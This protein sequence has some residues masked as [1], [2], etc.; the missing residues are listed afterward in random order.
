[1]PFQSLSEQGPL[2]RL[3]KLRV[4]PLAGYA[5]AVLSPVLAGWMRWMLAGVIID[6]IAFITFYPAIILSTFVGGLGPGV[7]A[8]ATSA[9]IASYFFLPPYWSFALTPASLASLALF[10]S[11]AAINVMLISL[12]NAVVD[13]IFT[14]QQYTRQIVDAVP[15]GILAVNEQGRMTFVNA[16]LQHLFGYS[17]DELV[18]RSVEVLVPTSV[19]S[20][21]AGLRANFLA[22]PQT[23]LMGA[24]R[25]L[26]GRRKDGSE[27]PVEI[28]LNA[29]RT[30]AGRAVLATVVDITERKRAEERQ[31]LLIGE[32]HHRTQNLFAVIQSI[33]SRSL[34][35]DRAAREIRDILIGRLRALSET[36]TTLT[37]SSWEGAS[38]HEIVK[39]E[40]DIFSN[41]IGIGGCDM[42]L[43]PSAA[44]GFALIV[45]ELAINAAKYGALSTPAGRVE[46][47]C[48]IEAVQEEDLFTF[49]WRETNGPPVNASGR[50]GFGT[51]ILDSAARQ[52]SDHIAFDYAPSG[53]RYVLQARASAIQASPSRQDPR[54]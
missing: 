43:S 46:V 28:G 44:Q 2:S 26:R 42:M 35:S 53:F 29:V 36:Y 51:T 38:L 30:S 33:T 22:D 18:G 48:S 21:H 15:S 17:R 24:G 49:R 27:F 1:M 19:Q 11:V 40:L 13:K 14:Q 23:R 4:Y 37:E 25:D 45:H 10:L 52:F 39:R 7:V 34:D 3:Q 50:K 47:E 32:L 6:G 20:H 8:T 31:K 12:L 9:L 54:H 5:I 16:V 41:R